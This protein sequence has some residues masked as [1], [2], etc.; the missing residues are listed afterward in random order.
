MIVAEKLTDKGPL[1][2]RRRRILSVPKEIGPIEPIH[3]PRAVL[4]IEYPN[5]K[6]PNSAGICYQGLHELA[7]YFFRLDRLATG[8]EHVNSVAALNLQ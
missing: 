6:L 2:V 1:A 8:S 5:F 4:R 3:A 7:Q